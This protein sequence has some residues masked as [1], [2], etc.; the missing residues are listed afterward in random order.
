M[1]ESEDFL[2]ILDGKVLGNREKV[3]NVIHQMSN[4]RSREVYLP[5]DQKLVDNVVQTGG[6]KKKARM[7]RSFA[8]A[9]YTELS[10][11][12][13]RG[14]PLAL[15]SIVREY[16]SP[17]RRLASYFLQD[18]P[19]VPAHSLQ[20]VDPAVKAAVMAGSTWSGKA[21]ESD[22]DGDSAGELPDGG[23]RAPREKA[24]RGSALI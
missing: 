20:R 6:L 23:S 24:K 5:Y 13:W 12:C 10:Y 19:I 21:A 7:F 8:T 22:E 18:V 3:R 14:R 1:K 9:V 2:I 16:V 4:W 11:V 17:G 15:L